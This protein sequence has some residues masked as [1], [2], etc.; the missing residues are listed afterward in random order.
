MDT[1]GSTIAI[2]QF[3]V[4]HSQVTLRFQLK[5]NFRAEPFPVSLWKILSGRK[6]QM[7][8]TTT[9][10]ILLSTLVFAFTFPLL[11]QAVVVTVVVLLCHEEEEVNTTDF[12]KLFPPQEHELQIHNCTTGLSVR[13]RDLFRWPCLRSK[14][15]RDHETWCRLV[16][17][18]LC[19]QGSES[20]VCRQPQQVHAEICV[21]E[22]KADARVYEKV[23]PIRGS[24]HFDPKVARCP[25][26]QSEGGSGQELQA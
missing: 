18:L 16:A 19:H 2:V 12:Y 22:W 24:V 15:G 21:T 4:S 3:I 23:L 1:T 20:D 8:V 26:R 9:I 11:T 10:I 6:P 5:I 17:K 14:P 13:S 25:V 7:Q